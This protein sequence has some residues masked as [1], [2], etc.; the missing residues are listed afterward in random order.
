MNLK[1]KAAEHF[2][3]C[4]CLLN[5]I[6]CFYATSDNKVDLIVG[7]SKFRCQIKVIQ[8]VGKCWQLPLRKTGG[9]NYHEYRYTSDDVD[10]MIGVDFNTFDIYII[11]INSVTDYSTYVTIGT[12]ERLGFK[13]NIEILK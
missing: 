11:P 1:G 6:E 5:G 12:L 13:N 2:V 3:I 7:S 9:Q 8:Y 10:F 4:Q